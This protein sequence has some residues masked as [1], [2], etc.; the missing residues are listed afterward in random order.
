MNKVVTLS[1]YQCPV[2]SMAMHAEHGLVEVYAV[3]GWMRGVLYE[4]HQ[5][6]DLAGEPEDVIFYEDIEIRE[7]WVHSRELKE[8]DLLKDVQNLV[9]RGQIF[10]GMFLG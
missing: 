7:I 8:A 6:N 9:K 2:G 4:H 5:E 1:S 3:N 10:K